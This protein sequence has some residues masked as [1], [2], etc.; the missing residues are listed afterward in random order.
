[1]SRINRIIIAVVLLGLLFCLVPFSA[2]KAEDGMAYII[3]HALNPEGIEIASIDGMS[4][5][6]VE[7]YDGDTFIG[8][9]AYNAET[10]NRPIQILTGT[11]TIKAKFNGITLEKTVNLNFG[12]TEVVTFTF[13]RVEFP[14]WNYISQAIPFVTYPDGSSCV[15]ANVPA[16]IFDEWFIQSISQPPEYDDGWG[17]AYNLLVAWITSMWGTAEYNISNQSLPPDFDP[18]YY[19]RVPAN[20]SY[21]EF[22]VTGP[23]P[24]TQ[25]T[26]IYHMSSVPFDILGTGVKDEQ[27][28]PPVAS[29]TYS[30]EKPIAGEGITFDASS[31]HDPDGTVVKYNWDCGDGNTVEG[32]L[33]N[34][35]Y[36]EIGIYSVSLIVTDNDGLTGSISKVIMVDEP[37]VASF[38]YYPYNCSSC[39]P[40]VGG[41]IAFDASSSSDPD[42]TITNC[43]WDFGDKSSDAG[44]AVEHI[45]T[46]PEK[47]TVTLTVTDNDGLTAST[48][49]D[50]DLTLRNGDILLCRSEASVVP[51]YWSHVGI[52][53]EASNSVIEART[54]GVG[55]FP[56][57]DWFFPTQT[58]VRAVGIDA[59]PAVR[60]AAVAFASTQ[61]GC[62]YD[63]L[64][65]L[66]NMKND[67]NTDRFGWYCSE[68]AWAAYLW[69]SNGLINLDM[70]AFAV[71]PDEIASSSWCHTIGE[72][73]ETIP[74]TI[75][76]GGGILWGEALCPVDLVITDPDGLVLNKQ[77]SN[78][79]GA[80]YG[81]L[82]IDHDGDLDVA[83]GIPEPKIGDYLV[84]V[85]PQPDA[86]PDDTYS[87]EVRLGETVIEL[88]HNTPVADIPAQGYILRSTETGIILVADTTPPTTPVVTDDG[89]FTTSSTQLH[90]AWSS[91]DNESVIA[92]YQYAIGTTQGGT[93]VVGWTSAGTA[94][95]A[96]CTGLSLTT[97]TKYY[98]S[99]KAKN[100]DGLWSDVGVSDGIA[101]QVEGDGNGDGNRPSTTSDGGG[102]P[103]WIW[104][105][106]GGGAGAIAGVGIL[107][108]F[109]CRRPR[110][111]N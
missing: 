95:E 107:T 26:D 54:N 90:V 94:T 73:K 50:I 86:S 19:E 38:T 111:Q 92:E 102:L 44:P 48:S 30:P 22:I 69:A 33:V 16:Q 76:T 68:L 14:A 63:L 97:G 61:I 25:I 91:S 78:I 70:D 110:A 45:F 64:S 109:L 51:G 21:I 99:V 24:T 7:I 75:Y 1:M 28:Q 17:M 84:Q 108:Y 58:C 11:H 31:S 3:V 9:G 52:Y 6:S 13:E 20:K 85:I 46:S 66:L 32:E 56:L 79:P 35:T 42:G 82:D 65:I 4:Q 105:V 101:V 100:V 89:Q 93:D 40:M 103:S 49:T 15:E 62:Q 34:H 23:E 5:Y 104:I 77:A 43:A 57:S 96:T 37:P 29:F 53:D 36:A 72:H 18:Y 83:F 98:I 88:T 8:Y 60:N 12:E 10:H 74:D 47:F 55:H 106:V 80:V 27:V 41:E 87:L 59:S 67:L 39:K 2:A 71:S 81:E